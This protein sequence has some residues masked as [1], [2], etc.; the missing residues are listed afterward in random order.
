MAAILNSRRY[1]MYEV[2]QLLNV[3]VATIWRWYLS[4]VKRDENFPPS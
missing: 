2:A 3:H 4:G 1:S